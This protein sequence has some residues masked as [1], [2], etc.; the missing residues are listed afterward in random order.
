MRTFEQ[1]F[2]ALESVTIRCQFVSF[3]WYPVCLC[4]KVNELILVNIH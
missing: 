1:T 4:F 3:V 2:C